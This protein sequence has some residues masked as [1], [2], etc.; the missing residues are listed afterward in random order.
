MTKKTALKNLIWHKPPMQNG[1]Q[2]P[3]IFR[4]SVRENE[5]QVDMGY[6]AYNIY[7][8]GG[9]IRIH[10]DTYLQDII[11]GLKYKMTKAVGIPISPEKLEFKTKTDWQYFSLLFEPLP[12]KNLVINLIEPNNLVNSDH[13]NNFE[14]LGI[15]L[16]LEKA[17]EEY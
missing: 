13:G 6:S 15:E 1:L 10:A 12:K 5:T 7:I 17:L 14:Y 3:S 8:N 9:W 4:I 11:S 2:N 16:N